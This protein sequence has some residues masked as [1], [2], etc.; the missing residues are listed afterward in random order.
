MGAWGTGNFDNDDAADWVLELQDA[1]D[2]S[3][4]VE[5][6]QTVTEHGDEYLEAPD[7]CRA[8]AAAEVIVALNQAGSPSLPDEV[9]QWVD[10]H[11]NVNGSRYVE[12]ALRAVGRVKTDSELKELFDESDSA[13]A[14]YGVL[15]DLAARLR[16]G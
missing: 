10:A 3:L 13:E 6:L 8:L 5:T 1:Q 12:L 16:R 4:V 7:C 15:D 9:R 11:R 14:W 2:L